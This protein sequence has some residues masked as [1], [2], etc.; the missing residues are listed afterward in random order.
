M[1]S[2]ST[3]LLAGL[4]NPA[5]AAA[6]ET[7]FAIATGCQDAPLEQTLLA[8]S[9]PLSAASFRI[10]R[11]PDGAREPA[12]AVM[13]D[14]GFRR[15][16]GGPEQPLLVLTAVGGRER[17]CIV[18]LS[19]NDCPQAAAVYDRLRGE[20]IPL[21]FDMETPGNTLVLHATTYRLEFLDGQGNHNTWRY[22]G[23]AH[24]LA[25]VIDESMAALESCLA[26]AR[27]AYEGR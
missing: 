19:V 17:S 24:P 25:T 9:A 26:P 15:D 7:P 10:A 2:V 16:L 1:K 3:L 23:I 11:L 20:S 4:M 14:R 8:A 27:A 5:A 22:A 13:L 21:G 18:R 6:H 12:L